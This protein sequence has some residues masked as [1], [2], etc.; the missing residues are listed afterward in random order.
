VLV[1]PKMK[2]RRMNRRI[3][4]YIITGFLCMMGAIM[5]SFPASADTYVDRY[6]D[7]G[8]DSPSTPSGPGDH[9]SST[10]CNLVAVQ[11]GRID[12]TGSSW[13][14]YKHV[15]GAPVTEM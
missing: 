6:T 7:G 3:T 4:K 2:E 15:P 9:P 11:G 1:L 13:I 10:G 14:F 12:C 5:F 8:D